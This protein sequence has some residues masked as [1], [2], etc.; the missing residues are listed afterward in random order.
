MTL[1]RRRI[2]IF[3]PHLDFIGESRGIPALAKALVDQGY[4]VDLLEAWR[5][6]SHVDPAE[7]PHLR[8]VPLHTRR[9]VPFLPN[10]SRISKWLSFRVQI[11]LI[12]LGMLPGLI[13]YLRAQRPDVLIA[14]QLTGPAVLAKVLSRGST[15]LILSMGGLPR[16]A[17]HRNRLWP[18]LYPRADAFTAPAKGVA[19]VA[20]AVSK[21]PTDR[22]HIIPDPVADEHLH[23]MA[24][25][26]VDEP[27]FNDPDIPVLLAVGRLTRQKDYPTL[28]NAFAAV[29]ATRAAHLVILGEGEDRPELEA[30]IARLGIAQDISMPGFV[31]NPFSFMRAADLFV[32]TSLWE[33]SAHSLMEVQA[34][35]TPSIATDCPSGQA[36]TL[37]HGASGVLVS[38]GDVSAVAEA[39]ND[40]LDNPTKASSLAEA[41]LQNGLRFT[42]E[43]VAKL[44]AQVIESACGPLTSLKASAHGD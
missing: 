29:R 33:G 36:E 43:R 41:G 42:P 40:L 6:W 19:E 7:S 3:S 14:R 26:P 21:V 35:G 15:R 23:A 13:G 31:E 32:M 25:E 34:V 5:E 28:I 8:V 44:W 1:S 11:L 4:D 20:S 38:V 18:L 2:A 16:P 39:I 12:T 24:Q 9:I 22:F 30:L 27:W 37:L 17:P 10:I